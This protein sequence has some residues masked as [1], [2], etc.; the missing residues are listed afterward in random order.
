MASL[1][2]QIPGGSYRRAEFFVCIP[3]GMNR[4]VYIK[5][6]LKQIFPQKISHKDIKLKK[7]EFFTH[8]V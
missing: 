8:K 6:L 5:Y 2:V 1:A 7:K 4:Y 3:P